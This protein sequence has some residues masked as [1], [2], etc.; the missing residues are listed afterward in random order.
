[1]TWD[2]IPS[3]FWTVKQYFSIKY[4]VEAAIHQCRKRPSTTLL[5]Q[6]KC[7]EGDYATTCHSSHSLHW[8]PG[9]EQNVRSQPPVPLRSPIFAAGGEQKS[10]Q[11]INRKG[12]T[13]MFP[14]KTD[15]TKSLVEYSTSGICL[16][17]TTSSIF[18]QKE[19]SSITLTVLQRRHMAEKLKHLI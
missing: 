7:A 3:G 2:G 13:Q 6:L 5:C 16:L 9:S 1:M 17:V 11:S 4:T 19:I 15:D 8:D 12:Q 14:W 18:Q 10:L